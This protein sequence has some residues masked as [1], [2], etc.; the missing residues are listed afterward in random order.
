MNTKLATVE[1]R[2]GLGQ[3]WSNTKSER[4]MWVQPV[5]NQWFQLAPFFMANPNP[6]V[7]SNWLEHRWDG[8]NEFCPPGDINKEERALGLAC[9]IRGIPE[10]VRDLMRTIT[11]PNGMMARDAQVQELTRGIHR[12]VR[13]NEQYAAASDRLAD[14]WAVTSATTDLGEFEHNLAAMVYFIHLLL[15]RSPQYL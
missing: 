13:D 12:E 2:R 7:L 15:I 8:M 11:V 6:I 3:F 1:P 10:R 14:N 9:G 4:E 5:E